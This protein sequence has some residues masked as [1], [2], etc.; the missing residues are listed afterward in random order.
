MPL[1]FAAIR[2]NLASQIVLSILTATRDV[3]T[4]NQQHALNELNQLPGSGRVWVL[5][6]HFDKCF[7]VEHLKK[8][9]K[10]LD[11]ITTEGVWLSLYDL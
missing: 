5:F 4:G 9:G 7:F 3:P 8:I 10:P 2:V 11:Q 6:A 1:N